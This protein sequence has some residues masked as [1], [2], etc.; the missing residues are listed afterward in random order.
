MV[1]RYN[2]WSNPFSS[3]YGQAY[4]EDEIARQTEQARRLAN[5]PTYQQPNFPVA[6]QADLTRNIPFDPSFSAFQFMD[7]SS[8]LFPTT[9][10]PTGKR[11]EV[12]SV[13]QLQEKQDM[14]KQRQ[15]LIDQGKEWNIKTGLYENIDPETGTF[16]V[17]PTA[18]TTPPTPTPEQIQ[19]QNQKSTAVIG[20]SSA[21][22]DILDLDILGIEPSG[23]PNLNEQDVNLR[24][25]VA[26][27]N[28]NMAK[29]NATG[30]YINN[31][32]LATAFQQAIDNNDANLMNQIHNLVVNNFNMSLEKKQA[33]LQALNESQADMDAILQS[34]QNI[35]QM[36]KQDIADQY[37]Q[38]YGPAGD[39]QGGAS[40]FTEDERV[41]MADFMG[42]LA[43]SQATDATVP[44]IPRDLIKSYYNMETRSWEIAPESQ[45]MID[46]MRD[47]QDARIQ[48]QRMTQ[49]QEA[50]AE[51]DQTMAQLTSDLEQERLQLTQEH[52][53]SLQEMRQ[54]MERDLAEEQT[55]LARERMDEEIALQ[56]ERLSLEIERAGT[57][58]YGLLAKV[59]LERQQ[60]ALL[61][62]RF[63][64]EQYEFGMNRITEGMKMAQEEKLLRYSTEEQKQLAR[65][66]GQ[67]QEDIAQIQADAHIEVAKQ[68]GL[69]AKEVAEINSKSATDVASTQRYSAAEV[70]RIQQRTQEN[71]AYQTG[72]NQE[73]VA[74][75]QTE[76]QKSIAS[77]QTEAEIQIAKDNTANNLSIATLTAETEE[78]IAEMS[79]NAQ[80]SVATENGLSDI[81]VATIAANST[82][83]AAQKTG[84]STQEVE[85]IRGEYNKLIADATGLTEQTI[86]NIQATNA[87]IIANIQ[88]GVALTEGQVQERIAA[89][90]ISADRYMAE[91]ARAGQLDVADVQAGV[92]GAQTQA[93]REIAEL[94]RQAQEYIA[95]TQGLSAEEVARIQ[96]QAGLGVA[97]TQANPFG[98]STQQ[99]LDLQG[100]QAR[101]GLTPEQRLA[102][103]TLQTTGGLTPQQQLEQTQIQAAGP[104][105]GLGVDQ[106]IALQE[107]LARGGLTPDQQIQL[108]QAQQQAQGTAA[109]AGLTPQDYVSLQESVAR[110]GLTP[111]QRLAEQQQ[112]Q[113]VQGLT[114]LLTLLSNPSAL[115]AL[116]ALTTGQ[117]PFGGAIPSAAALQGRSNEFLNFLQGAFGA[118]GVTPSAL[119]NLI[120][121]VTPAGISNPFGALGGGVA[122]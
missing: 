113:Q 109:R 19:L 54:E 22:A 93:D 26:A 36:A 105:A 18:P 120:Q 68:T 60:Q 87:E 32:N 44:M 107:S 89:Q 3:I 30:L 121:G 5:T 23:S 90:Q 8:P 104:R 99:Y 103:L 76:A 41:R 61:E 14:D 48:S 12:M 53:R 55:K 73:E 38:G 91:Q 4:N 75:I 17:T 1:N 34:E 63:D 67:N 66:T 65:I 71:V 39:G 56:Q 85:R 118:L 69:T 33:S 98:L 24:K 45:Q 50:I 111:E 47:V 84:L 9:G 49:E 82:I 15:A 11:G 77:T 29:L 59:D 96:A 51:R 86:A 62:R 10:L 42:M 72:L 88:A 106:Y 35:S 21:I 114:A 116:S 119:V 115:G 108:Y 117:T 74:R 70:A 102:E 122:T 58:E 43:E 78:A 57:E 97:Q 13:S 79:T 25:N 37:P 92:A 40:P 94:Q 7:Q 6:S 46:M 64:Q 52:E 95:R 2:D 20:S 80:I 31:M 81:E 112:G 27:R 16:P 100:Q 28:S 101:G 83:E 110:G